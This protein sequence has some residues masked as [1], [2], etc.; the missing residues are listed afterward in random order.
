MIRSSLLNMANQCNSGANLRLM[1]MGVNLQQ[2]F[3]HSGGTPHFKKN[4]PRTHESCCVTDAHSFN[5]LYLHFPK[6]GGGVENHLYLC[7]PI[8][9]RSSFKFHIADGSQ[10]F[11]I[12]LKHVRV[13]LVF[14]IIQLVGSPCW[15]VPDAFS[16][17]TRRGDPRRRE[18]LNVCKNTRMT[19]TAHFC[20]RPKSLGYR[21]N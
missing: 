15:N 12:M 8:F 1:Q 4:L 14:L 20:R 5:F 21:N 19:Y 17:I 6:G 2:L 7:Y 16:D 18:K 9:N 3:I 10:V 11:K 13:Q